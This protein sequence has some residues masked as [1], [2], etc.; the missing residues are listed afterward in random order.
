MKWLHWRSKSRDRDLEEEIA[1]DLAAE[2]DENTA[3]GMSPDE[4]ARRSR[5][6]FGKLLLVKEATREIRT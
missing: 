4:A 1:Y 6:D 2:A 3:C 5:R